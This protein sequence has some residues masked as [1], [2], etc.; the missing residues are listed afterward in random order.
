[1]AGLVVLAV[2]ASGCGTATSPTDYAAEVATST[3]QIRTVCHDPD[4]D[5][6]RVDL[7]RV[8]LIE[9]GDMIIADY[10]LVDA[11][12]SSTTLQ[13]TVV[14]SKPGTDSTRRLIAVE[15][16][17][18]EI[19]QWV[20]TGSGGRQRVHEPAEATAITAAVDYP[21]ST[22]NELGPH[23]RWRAVAKVDGATQDECSAHGR[24]L[25][26]PADT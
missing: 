7:T 20:S 24:T 3:S 4:G 11:Q 9:S 14:V 2:L 10:D 17:E 25:P 15:P 23:W 1:M 22:I 16:P 5:G 26:N 12:P 6:G 19:T 8:T 18:H 21:V 13:L